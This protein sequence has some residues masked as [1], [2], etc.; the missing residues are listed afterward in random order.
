MDQIVGIEWLKW[1]WLNGSNQTSN[2]WF[3]SNRVMYGSNKMGEC[4]VLIKELMY[5]SNLFKKMLQKNLYHFLKFRLKIATL[6]VFLR[7]L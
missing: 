2:V 1:A 5:V 6:G 3:K 7:Y 4:M